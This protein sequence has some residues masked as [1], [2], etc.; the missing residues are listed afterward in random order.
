MRQPLWVI[1]ATWLLLTIASCHEQ[2]VYDQYIP[3]PLEGWAKDDT[4]TFSL[5]KAE[6]EGVYGM[7]L[8]LRS[9][10]SYPFMGITLIVEKTFFPSLFKSIDT[11][12]CQLREDNGMPRQQGVSYYQNKLYIGEIRLSQGDSLQVSVRHDMKRE[13]LPGIGDVG[14][15]LTKY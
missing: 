6:T 11:I 12:P 7:D 13:T 10:G 8:K 15:M 9:N 2:K 4:L 1:W 5:P 14:I 3:T